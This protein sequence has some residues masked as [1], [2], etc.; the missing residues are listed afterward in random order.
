LYAVPPEPTALPGLTK[1]LRELPAE[2]A[3]SCSATALEELLVVRALG[4]STEA[5]RRVLI[6]AWTTL[7]PNVIGRPAT[8]P[9]IWST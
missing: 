8:L 9:R 2:P 7:R 5:V 4:D 1:V 6:R 3:V